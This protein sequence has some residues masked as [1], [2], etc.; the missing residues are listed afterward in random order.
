VLEVETNGVDLGA[1][2]VA[3]DQQDVAL[4]AADGRESAGR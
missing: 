2:V 1:Q 3:D 4:R